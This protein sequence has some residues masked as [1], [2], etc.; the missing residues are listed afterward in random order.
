M[1]LQFNSCLKNI[2]FTFGHFALHSIY[3]FSL[4]HSFDM[5]GRLFVA[6][7]TFHP[8]EDDFPGNCNS[9][10]DLYWVHKH[11]KILIPRMSI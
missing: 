5:L 1:N 11:W 7:A 4:G 3:K 2:A 10:L 6:E 8:A 9:E